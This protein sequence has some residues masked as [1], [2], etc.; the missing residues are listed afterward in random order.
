[1]L[2]GLLQF[3]ARFF[4]FLVSTVCHP[5]LSV[6]GRFVAD[7][8]WRCNILPSKKKNLALLY[9]TRAIFSYELCCRNFCYRRLTC[10][11]CFCKSRCN[12]FVISCI[13]VFVKKSFI[14]LIFMSDSIIRTVS[15]ADT[16]PHFLLHSRKH[17]DLN[18]LL[19][20]QLDFVQNYWNKN[21]GNFI[22]YVVF[23]RWTNLKYI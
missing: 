5:D 13:S 4:N 8:F 3:F 16:S 19:Q 7:T 14:L 1:M 21:G 23:L 15:T 18:I 10:I 17:L 20:S 9:E 22:S 6:L 11:M 12:S 2:Y